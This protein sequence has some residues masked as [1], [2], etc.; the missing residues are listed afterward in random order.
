MKAGEAIWQDSCAAC[1]RMDG[2]GVPRYFPPLKRNP[3][4]QQTDP[5]TLIHFVLAGTRKIPTDN[6]PTP[7]AMPAFEWKLSDDQVAAVLTYVRNSWGNVAQPVKAEQVADLRKKLELHVRAQ[8][9][10]PPAKL[11]NPGPETLTR[12]GTDSRDNGT[13]K[14]GQPAPQN[15]R[16]E[17][18]GGKSGQG[19]GGGGQSKSG[20]SSASKEKGGGHPA[21]VPTGGSG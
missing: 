12:S 11:S 5:T 20:G 9:K 14:A 2:S 21:G 19:S 6:A 3:N 4:A 8:D 17:T 16:I 1:H 10:Q 13:A 18:A 15:L 7:L